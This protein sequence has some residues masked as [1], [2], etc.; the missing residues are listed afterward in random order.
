[1]ISA[2]A[3]LKQRE[4]QRWFIL[5]VI[6][7]AIAAVIGLHDYISFTSINFLLGSFA[8][9]SVTQPT[10]KLKAGSLYSLLALIFSLSC[11]FIP[12]R[13][14]LYFAL[15]AAVLF[16]VE[17]FFGGL[18]F[19]P[20]VAVILASPIF[21]Y[22]SDIFSFPIR[23]KLTEW[24]ANILSLTGD[25]STAI[26][27][28]IYHNGTEMSVD[29]ECM[30]LN[31]MVTS[32]L[33]GVV[34][35]ATFARKRHR[36]VS[37]WNMIVHLVLIACLNVI[38]N[39]LRIMTLVHFS[40]QPGTAAHEIIGILFFVIYVVVPGILIA[41]WMTK[42]SGTS[43]DAA[44]PKAN[45]WDGVPRNLWLHFSIALLT[46]IAVV[47]VKQHDERIPQN[48]Q[49]PGIKDY[50]ATR[51][52]G[53]ILKLENKSSL[54]YLKYLPAFYSADHNPMICWKGSGYVFMK[55]RPEEIDGS[56]IFTAELD[57]NNKE[58]LFTAWWYENGNSRT[59][60]QLNWRK[61]VLYGSRNYYL[62]NVTAANR[63]GLE[64]EVRH[65]HSNIQLKKFFL[66]GR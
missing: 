52:S 54:I 2:I 59:I 16:L 24:S 36:T 27:N 33:T 29:P 14:V 46:C 45:H 26:G 25:E 19:L 42:K 55:V 12:G 57:R 31:M 40:I 48:I 4:D 22:A 13:T 51:I 66:D 34:M 6:M 44:H 32:T 28:M 38:S 1:M 23:L 21:R 18:T 63:S 64:Q 37:M 58:K 49:L 7:Y 15:S 8:I 30:G 39:L 41:R 62:V 35:F 17:A 9:L 60:E 43:K 10:R 5:L 47:S 11:L 20:F 56:T 3:I 65:L 61:D 53:E 50:K